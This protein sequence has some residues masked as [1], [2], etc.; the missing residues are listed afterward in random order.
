MLVIHLKRFSANRYGSRDKISTNIDFPLQ[1]LDLTDRT[2][3]RR[4][5][6]TLVTTPEGREALGPEGLN[7]EPL[8]YDLFAVDNHFGGLGGGHYTAFAMNTEDGKWYNFDDVGT[9]ILSAHSMFLTTYPLFDRAMLLKYLILSRL[10]K[11]VQNCFR[12]SG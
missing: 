10:S 4:L 1:G 8:V 5:A 7:K 11:Y 3:Y 9:T 2:I 6:D 12:K